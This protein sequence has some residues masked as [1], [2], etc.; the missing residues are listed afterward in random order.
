MS[1]LTMIGAKLSE[2]A[3]RYR[4]GELHVSREGQMRKLLNE[5]KRMSEAVSSGNLRWIQCD[6]CGDWGYGQETNE[7]WI[8]DATVCCPACW[9]VRRR[10][11]DSISVL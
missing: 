7:W 4:F 1:T 5:L 6:H 8:E 2:I 11:D 9:A 10:C 3:D